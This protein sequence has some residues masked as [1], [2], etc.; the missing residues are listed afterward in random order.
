MPDLVRSDAPPT[1]SPVAVRCSPFGAAA[2]GCAVLAWRPRPLDDGTL[3]RE[4]ENEDGALVWTDGG[5]S[6]LAVADGAGGHVGGAHASRLVLDALTDALGRAAGVADLRPFVLDAFE[7]ANAG[8]RALDTG[9]GSTLAVAEL[10]GQRLRTYHAGDSEVLVIGQR[11]RLLYQTL[12]HG[13]TA[14]AV[15]AGML[16]PADALHHDERHVI[17]SAL[18]FEE[19]RI[20]L[21]RLERVPARATVVVASDGLTDNVTTDE[22]VELARRGPLVRAAESL[23]ALAAR[24]MA[25]GDVDAPSKPDDLGLV[26]YRARGDAVTA[27]RAVTTRPARGVDAGAAPSESAG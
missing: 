20:E 4:R 16:D 24:R 13:P 8:I 21:G 9:A 5:R 1:P 14:Y 3:A 10:D 22:I 15:E 6:V 26:L 19:L 7:R 18:G 11:G 12:S 27:A 2:G 23:V 17:S 25:G